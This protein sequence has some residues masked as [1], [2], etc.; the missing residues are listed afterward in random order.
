MSS[1]QM[2]GPW[3]TE[4]ETEFVLDALS[5]GWYGKTAYSYVE[6]FEREFADYHGRRFGLMTPNCTTALHLLLAGMGIGPEDDVIAPECTWIGSTAG[7]SYVGANTIFADI[8]KDNWCLTPQT[9]QSAITERTKAVIV[10]DL[11][12]NMPEWDKITDLCQSKGITVIEDAAEAVGSVYRD[13]RAGNFGVASVFSF[14]R[15][16]TITCGEG[17]ILLLDDEHLF[18]R[19]KFLRDHGRQPGTYY[20]TEVTFKYM[21][22][23]LQAALAYGQFTRIDEL[24]DKKRWILNGYKSRLSDIRDLSLNPEPK[25]MCNGA[26]ATALV[27]GK[28]HGITRDMALH[29][30]PKL[31]LPVRPFFIH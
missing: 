9:I 29:E 17:G 22:F 15:T 11:Y 6:R 7:I 27:F 13:R 20:N 26:W 30:L 28:S 14:H 19:C 18:E 24:V 2:A 4:V 25:H 21:P 8:D 5:N 23:N 12:G 1:I 16:K 31:D 3:V 10:V